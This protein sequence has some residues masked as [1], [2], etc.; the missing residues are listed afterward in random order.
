MGLNKLGFKSS[1]EYKT[2]VSDQEAHDV[3]TKTMHGEWFRGVSSFASQR[4]FDWVKKGPV[5]K[6]V[7]PRVHKHVVG[8]SLRLNTG[9]DTFFIPGFGDWVL[10]QNLLVDGE[11]S[12]S[13]S[14]LV[15]ALAH[16][17]VSA[18]GTCLGIGDVQVI[19]TR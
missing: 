6:E 17:L 7:F 9:D 16:Q 8:M 19:G 13:G 3:M 14:W 10:D 5:P 12:E 2:E 1:N 11:R 4:S 18:I 15:L